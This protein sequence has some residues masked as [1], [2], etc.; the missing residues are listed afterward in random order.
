[1]NKLILFSVSIGVLAAC[2]QQQAGGWKDMGQVKIG[3]ATSTIFIQVPV[4]CRHESLV[5]SGPPKRICRYVSKEVYTIVQKSQYGSY[6]QVFETLSS[7][8]T[9]GMMLSGDVTYYGAD[10]KVV[11]VD[12]TPATWRPVPKGGMDEKMQEFVCRD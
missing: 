12:K 7:D 6:R 11:Y 2:Q 3:T 5:V 10:N 4:N 8:C 1:M 9:D